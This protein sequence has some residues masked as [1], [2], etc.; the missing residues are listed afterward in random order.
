MQRVLLMGIVVSMPVM[1][2][3]VTQTPRVEVLAE[4][5]VYTLTPPNNGSGPLW[6]YGCTQVARLGRDVFISQMETGEGV[7]LLANTRWRLLRRTDAGW[8]MAAEADGYRQREPCSVATTSDRRL[9]LYVNDSVEP[10]GT[11]YGRC[12]PHLLKFE[13]SK[14]LVASKI[15]PSW[16]GEPH[17]TDHSYRGFAADRRRHR[18]LMLNIDAKTSV[19]N[20]CLLSAK[21]DTLATGSITFPIRACYP[22]VALENA[23]VHVLAIGDIVE[24]VQEWRAYKFEQTK[25]AWDYVFR[26]LYYT[27]TPDITRHGFARPVEIANV[28]KTAGHIAN[29]DLWISPAGE[30]YILYTE[31]EVQ[32]GLVRDRFF[33]GKSII[34]SLYLAVV[35]DGEIRSRRTLIAGAAGSEPGCARFH[36]AEDGKLYAVVHVT[37]PEAGDK[38]M[39]VYPPIENPPLVAIPLKKPFGAFCL[40]SVRAGN[41]P[42][43]IIDLHGQTQGNKLSYAQIRIR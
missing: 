16:Q 42:S 18:L 27:W 28:D 2:S 14:P 1:G 35:K 30:A 23:A 22:Q 3:A 38:L 36:V 4:E 5:D 32:N 26:I 19:Q 31:R 15:M 40:A 12:E 8:R 29:Q 39:Q 33:P 17:Y 21:G 13:C 20:A 43:A 37:G 11:K 25:S 41:K 9:F 24:P 10:P 34:G 7:P 6:S